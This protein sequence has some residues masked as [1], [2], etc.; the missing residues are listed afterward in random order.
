MPLPPGNMSYRSHRSVIYHIQHSYKEKRWKM[1][2]TTTNAHK[3]VDDSFQ[4]SCSLSLS[5]QRQLYYLT[6]IYGGVVGWVAKIDEYGTATATKLQ[7]LGDDVIEYIQWLESE[8][9]CK[10]SL[11][12]RRN[13]IILPVHTL[14]GTH[15]ARG[16]FNGW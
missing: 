10:E 4:V 12:H 5:S 11:R 9:Q 3:L 14:L 13:V 6:Y 16:L 15:A 2:P 1:L 8:V 7:W